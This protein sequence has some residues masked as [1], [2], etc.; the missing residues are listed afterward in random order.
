MLESELGGAYRSCP[1]PLL[2]DG[3][4]AG[5]VESEGGG[6]RPVLL[7]VPGVP[8]G[9]EA[10]KGVAVGSCVIPPSKPGGGATSR[11]VF[12][13][14]MLMPALPVALRLRTPIILDGVGDAVVTLGQASAPIFDV[15]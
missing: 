7:P 3:A 15:L 12:P 5:P 14:L 6:S 8:M 2:P 1:L 9:R 10:L 13:E 11:S 4:G